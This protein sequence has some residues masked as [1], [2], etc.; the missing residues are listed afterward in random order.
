MHDWVTFTLE[1]A[2]LAQRLSFR[3]PSENNDDRV[4]A[5]PKATHLL[6]VLG[7]FFALSLVYT[8]PLALAPGQA[9][10]FD[11]PDALLNAWILDWDT[12]ELARNPLK[13]FDAD[14]FFPEPGVLAYSE[15]LLSGALLGAPVRFVTTSP[16]LLFNVVLLLGFATTGFATYG[17]AFDATRDPLASVLA[18]VLFAF[19]PFRFAHIPHVQLQLAFGIPLMLLCARRLAAHSGVAWPLVGL[20]LSVPLTF[21]S[22]VYYTVF[23]ATAVPLVVLFASRE[24]RALGRVALGLAAGGFLTLPLAYPYLSKLGSGTERSLEAA[25]DFSA[26]PASYLSSFSWL[27]RPFSLDAAEPL[28]PGVA[29]LA[30]A[31]FALSRGG[32]AAW[33]WLTVAGLGAILSFGPKLGLFTLLFELLPPY[34]ALRVPS[35]AGVLFLLGVAVLAALGAARLKSRKLRWGALALVAAECFAAPLPFSMEAPELPTIY[36][37]VAELPGPGAVVELPMAPPERFQDNAVYVYRSIFYERP[38]VNGYSGFVPESYREHFELVMRG[39][40]APGLREL[41]SE[42]V[43]YVLAHE[44]RLGPRLRRENRGGRAVRAPRARC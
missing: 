42:G 1:L 21:G 12:S 29:A 26:G 9:N 15:N 40:L 10:R 28:F 44:G 11:S 19:A 6:L 23:A 13:V 25:R 24:P 27:H 39:E 20:A 7:G 30:L 5:P 2:N 16:V 38:L 41:S 4:R 36:G 35:R 3:G 43:R 34:R 17:L 14:I 18:G 32:R 8:F 22:S 37:A 33:S 31:G